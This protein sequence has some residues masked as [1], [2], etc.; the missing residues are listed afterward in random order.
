MV[1]AWID[2]WMDSPIP[3]RHIECAC[4]CLKTVSF[5]GVLPAGKNKRSLVRIFSWAELLLLHLVILFSCCS[6]THWRSV[7]L[8]YNFTCYSSTYVPTEENSKENQDSEQNA[9]LWPF[10]RRGNVFF[11]NVL[12][13]PFCPPLVFWGVLGILWGANMGKASPLLARFLAI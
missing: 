9:Q 12:I 7:A 11:Q 10:L 3:R 5:M 6:F 8:V 13:D 1:L 4:S 2:L